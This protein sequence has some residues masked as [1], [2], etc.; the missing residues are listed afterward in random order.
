VSKKQKQKKKHYDLG[1][2]SMIVMQFCHNFCNPGQVSWRIRNVWGRLK[3]YESIA[4]TVSHLY[5]YQNAVNAGERH[6]LPSKIDQMKVSQETGSEANIK[7]GRALM[8]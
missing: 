4:I 8:L 3:S 5:F 7:F 1:Y 6:M 2:Q